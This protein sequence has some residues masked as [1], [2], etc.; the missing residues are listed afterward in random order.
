MKSRISFGILMAMV[1]GTMPCGAAQAGAQAAGQAEG[2]AT[3][4]AALDKNKPAAQASAEADAK[5]KAEARARID[6]ILQRG[7]R[8]SARARAN[9]VAK[10]EETAR[11][12]DAHAATQGDAKIAER[13][14]A[15]F[16]TSAEALLA[17]KQGL[18]ESWGEL[19]IAHTLLAS[20]GPGLTIEQLFEMRGDA[21]WGVIAAGLGFKLGEVVSA[22][23]AESR[24]ALGL[25]RAD[26]KVAAVHGS[27]ARADGSA[28]AGVRGGASGVGVGVGAETGVGVGLR[29]KP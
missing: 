23:R 21:G 7:A 14:A 6:A 10:L 13:F 1:L 15:E 9:A 22:V 11:E 4:S 29:V 19:M 20:A 24:V 12:V 5:A 17:E 8:T 18:G 28:G 3:A 2:T 27:G 16:G 25:V 26:G